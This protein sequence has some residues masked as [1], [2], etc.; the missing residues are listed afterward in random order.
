MR[1]GVGVNPQ[2]RKVQNGGALVSDQFSTEAI[3]SSF[4]YAGTRS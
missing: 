1:S 4:C 2:G 3:F